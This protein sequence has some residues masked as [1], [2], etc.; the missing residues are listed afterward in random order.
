MPGVDVWAIETLRELILALREGRRPPALRIVKSAPQ[1]DD[2][3][4]GYQLDLGDVVGQPT[5]RARHRSGGRRWASRL[6]ARR[7][8]HRED[9]A[10]G[11]TARAAA[12]ARSCRGARSDRGAFGG[13]RLAAGCPLM[14]RPPFRDPHHTATIAALVGGGSGLAKPA[15][16]RSPMRACCF[17][18]RPR[19]SRAA[20]G[21]VAA[22]A[23]EPVTCRLRGRW[24]RPISGAVPARAGRQP[25]RVL[26]GGRRRWLL[27]HCACAPPIPQPAVGPAAR[28]GRPAGA[29]GPGRAGRTV[30]GSGHVEPAVWWPGGCLP[31]GPRRAS[32][33][34]HTMA[35]EQPDSGASELRGQWSPPRAAMVAAERA[36]DAGRLSLRGL[37][38][39]CGCRGP[40][41]IWPAGRGRP[42]RTSTKRSTCEPAWPHD[43]RGWRHAGRQVCADIADQ[44][45]RAGR[46]PNLPIRWLMSVRSRWSRRC[47]RARW[48]EAAPPSAARGGY[49]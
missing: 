34:G 38:R 5:G 16:P 17:S 31:R 43:A 8:G 1:T 48:H 33:R 30:R 4:P 23:G 44:S 39:V 3:E 13:R 7:S 37:D 2:P 19:S 12:G 35:A 29:D 49:R 45:R 14:T 47:G 15:W 41:P 6:P 27:L 20:F 24:G 42:P 28:P 26:D 36:L 25:V 9:D 40:W 18:T 21:R 46:S 22:T 11:A 32:A 10:G